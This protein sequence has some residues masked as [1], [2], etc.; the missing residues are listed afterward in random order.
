M[1]SFLIPPHRFQRIVAELFPVVAHFVQCT[2][3]ALLKD[4]SPSPGWVLPPVCAAQGSTVSLEKP[5]Y[6]C[7]SGGTCSHS[8]RENRNFFLLPVPVLRMYHSLV[9]K[10][11]SGY[12]FCLCQLFDAFSTN[13]TIIVATFV[14]MVKDCWCSPFLPQQICCSVM[15][16]SA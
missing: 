12:F 10:R 7:V 1:H 5:L 15:Q 6:P 11:Q 9:L 13:I 14:H 8:K 4:P 3:A 2:G 16:Y